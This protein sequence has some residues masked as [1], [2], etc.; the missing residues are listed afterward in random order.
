[1][2]TNLSPQCKSFL[3]ADSRAGDGFERQIVPFRFESG[4]PHPLCLFRRLLFLE[5]EDRLRHGLEPGFRDRLAARIRQAVAALLDLMQGAL[6]P[7]Q[8][9]VVDAAQRAIDIALGAVL[10]A[11]LG[12][13]RLAIAL[14]AQAGL[15]RALFRFRA[16]KL[17]AQR[18]E[19]PA[20]RID[21]AGVDGICRVWHGTVQA[22]GVS[23]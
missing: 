17:R 7:A 13:L 15:L 18:G 10:R 20:L 14:F 8:A 2:L 11:L 19:A 6:D 23:P 3:P 16:E 22:W 9:P 12:L 4:R 5:G 1:M 21:E